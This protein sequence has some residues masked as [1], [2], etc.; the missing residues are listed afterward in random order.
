[1]YLY[2]SCCVYTSVP[3]VFNISAKIPTIN[4]TDVMLIYF[5]IHMQTEKLM[6]AGSDFCPFLF[7]GL[8]ID[9]STPKN[10]LVIIRVDCYLHLVGISILAKSQIVSKATDSTLQKIKSAVAGRCYFLIFIAWNN[11]TK[12]E[13]VLGGT[14]PSLHQYY[15]LETHAPSH[16]VHPPV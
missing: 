7:T 15:T 9:P 8:P 6:C 16:Q 11:P 3:G 4:C 10:K 2:Q 14:V 1:M 13:Y 12:R 5:G